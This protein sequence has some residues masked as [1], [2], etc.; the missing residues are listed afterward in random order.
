MSLNQH[1]EAFNR[2]LSSYGYSAKEVSEWS[3]IHVSRL[4]RF[5]TGKLDLGAG[6]FLSLLDCF[7]D[8]FQ[9]RFWRELQVVKDD[10]RS[11][12]LSASTEDIE[13]IC[14]GVADWCAASRSE[15]VGSG[16]AKI[17]S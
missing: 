13:E 9:S 12:V 14:R 10:W 4:S 15:M 16:H 17:A 8:E 3:G 11:R 7:P 2:L 1:R 6:E 5:R